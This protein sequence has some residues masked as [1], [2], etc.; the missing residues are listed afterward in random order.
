MRSFIKGALVLAL[1]T[2]AGCFGSFKLTQKLY[3]FND[4]LSDSIVVKEIVFL[5]MVIVPVYGVGMFVDGFALNLIEF[6][7]GSNPIADTRLNTNGGQVRFER[8]PR[9]IDV[10]VSTDGVERIRTFRKSYG[11]WE[12]LD[13]TG[14]RVALLQHDPDG[15][16]TVVDAIGEPLA[17]YSA[18]DVDQLVATVQAGGTDELLAAVRLHNDE[19][20]ASY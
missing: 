1:A 18:T 19:S 9:G 4:G 13:E 7:T 16:L 10:I 12:V 8:G 11:T 14:A 5:A 3:Q 17:S 20:V 2:Q 6:I 15:G